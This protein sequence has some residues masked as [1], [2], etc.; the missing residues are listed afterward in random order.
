LKEKNPQLKVILPDPVGSI[1]YP[2]F[3]TGRIPEGG[4][5]NYYVEGVGEDHLAK[6]L[7]FSIVDD[8]IPF[9]DK[10]AF[11]TCRRLAAEEGILTGGSSGANVKIAL[12]IAKTLT[13]PT[14]LVVIIPDGGVKYLS[15][16]Y[17]DAWMKEKG[18]L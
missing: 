14:T 8:V 18:L 7:D 9:T 6:A 12:D 15:K 2:Y 5:C 13:R 16:I 11:E 10:E 4:N 17:N 3:K 1:Y